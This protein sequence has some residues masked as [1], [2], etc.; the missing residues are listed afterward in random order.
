M[1]DKIFKTITVEKVE[2]IKDLIVGLDS[3]EWSYIKGSIDMYFSEKAA[4]IKIDDLDKIDKYL[5]RKY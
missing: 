3:S 4:N 2:S 5:K 1:N